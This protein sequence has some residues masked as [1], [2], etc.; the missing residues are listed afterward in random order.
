MLYDISSGPDQISTPSAIRHFIFTLGSEFEPIQN[1]FRIDILP[2]KWKNADWPTLL[3]LCRDYFHSVKPQGVSKSLPLTEGFV[4]HTAHRKKVKHWFMNPLK[5]CKEIEAEQCKYSNKCI[6]HLSKTHPTEECSVKKECDK[7][8]STKK[9]SATSG[10]NGQLRHI[11]EVTTQDEDLPVDETE[12]SID[13]DLHNDTNE[14]VLLYFSHV[15]SH[16][17]RLVKTKS[18]LIIRH[19]MD[20]PIIADSGANF[21]M[22]RDREFFQTLQP[23][24]GQ[25]ILGDG[26]TTLPIQGVGTIQ[27][28][29]GENI[30]SVDNVRFVPGLSESIYSL[31]LHIRTPG[32]GL[33]SLFDDGLHIQFPTFSTKAILGTDDVYLDGVPATLDSATHSSSSSIQDSNTLLDTFQ[34]NCRH[35][36][37]CDTTVSIPSQKEDNLIRNLRHYYDEVRTK[38]QLNMDVPAGFRHN[39][40]FQRQVRD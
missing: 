20:Y 39:T 28:R 29:I 19:N 3:I 22:F 8:L 32:H 40:S 7:I 21:H 6:Y 33:C 9:S 5:F 12:V 23:A 16:Y 4:N 24:T 15:T 27:L 13:D 36:T 18:D 38:R 17:L 1:N 10:T 37:Q 31:F 30:L 25:V 26:K 2:E 35:I 14:E 11:T 34:A